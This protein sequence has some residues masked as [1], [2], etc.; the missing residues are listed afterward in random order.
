MAVNGVPSAASDRPDG[1]AARWNDHRDQRRAA[2]VA[3]GAEA[4]DR[5]GPEASAG[6][7]AEVAGVSRTVLYRYFADK[8]DLQRAI[9]E[10]IVQTALAAIT[11]LLVVDVRAT[12]MNIING[13]IGS[14]VLFL[15]QHP[16]QYLFLR[17]QRNVAGNSIEAIES[18]LAVQVARLLGAFIS[19]F[20]LD[21]AHAEPAAHGIVGLVESTIAW[22]LAHRTVSRDQLVDFIGTSVWFVIDGQLKAHGRTLDPNVP[23]PIEIPQ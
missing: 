17:Q 20:G 15:D 13:T 2:F 9:G 12:P 21:E 7:I 3:A 11:P 1:R 8:D 14:V 6:Q 16:N 23:L 4:I 22:W 18:T 19:F 10:Y 5:Y